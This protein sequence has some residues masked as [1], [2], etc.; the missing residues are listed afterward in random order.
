ML[1]N[2]LI[3]LV[4]SVLNAG[5]IAMGYTG[6][7]AIEVVQN[8]QPTAQ[9]VNTQNTVYLNKLGDHR[10]GYLERTNVWDQDTETM[11]HTETQFY[12]TMFQVN[13]LAIQDPANVNSLTASDI[14][15]MAAAVLQSDVSRGTLIAAG[16]NILRITDVRN[17]YFMDDKDRFEADPSFDFTLEH[18]Q[19]IVS[20]APIVTDIVVNI[21][22]V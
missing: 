9:G 1:D 12:E 21:D 22:R 17:P 19:V 13:G 18:E 15:N 11:V 8:F 20:T 2:A 6:A 5:F 7:T 14:V 3:A 16:V 10:Y 4:I